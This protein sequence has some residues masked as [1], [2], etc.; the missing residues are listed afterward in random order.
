MV[1]L[2]GV[3][4]NTLV[5]ILYYSFTNCYDWEAMSDEYPRNLCVTS[6]QVN[7]QLPHNDFSL[8]RNYDCLDSV[9][10]QL[11]T[12]HAKPDNWDLEPI[13]LSAFPPC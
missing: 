2:D 1:C 4:I 6:L 12:P 7:L 13:L 8:E 9:I 10:A 5:L 11:F 3:S